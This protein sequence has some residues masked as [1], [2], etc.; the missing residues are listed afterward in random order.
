M[1]RTIWLWLRW[2]IAVFALGALVL[3]TIPRALE[4]IA[5]SVEFNTGT[6]DDATETPAPPTIAS[7]EPEVITAPPTGPVEDGSANPL[8]DFVARDG[9][10]ADASGEVLE[11]TDDPEDALVLAYDR[12]EG[13]PSCVAGMTL[14]I[15]VIDGTTTELGAY[16]S[17]ALDAP[18]LQD[19][20][21]LPDPLVVTEIPA[22][23]LT[24]GTPGRLMWD[25]TALYQEWSAA[26]LAPPDAPFVVAV[27]ATSPVEEGG[28]VEFAA[29]ESGD[30]APTLTWTGV[31]GC[32]GTGVGTPDPEPTATS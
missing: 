29:L 10:V 30:E 20:A 31:P 17:A 19:F 12:I 6:G 4:A 3:W 15:E 11:L 32:G 26:G 7:T 5:E 14:E 13:D 24:N 2:P 28:G 25:L 21:T 8:A 16:A 22:L 23:A 18:E 9:V 1:V 27:R